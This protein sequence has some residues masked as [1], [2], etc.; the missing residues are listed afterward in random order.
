MIIAKIPKWDD[1]KF[2]V[3]MTARQFQALA[4][5]IDKSK[6]LEEVS[7]SGPVKKHRVAQTC[8][9]SEVK[10]WI[11]NGWN[12]EL[13]LHMTKEI[14]QR[15]VNSAALHWSFP[16][17]YYSVYALTLAY[18]EVAGFTTKSHTSVIR[19]FGHLVTQRQYPNSISF[20]LQGTRKNSILETSPNQRIC[21][22]L[23]SILRT[24]RP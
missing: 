20:G 24:R 1:A 11:R 7:N 19:Q 21:T 13:L 4:I 5:R 6:L 8:S 9:D 23:N 17:A 16:Q 14:I 12:T 18:F 3:E 22:R 10:K 2:R 15:D